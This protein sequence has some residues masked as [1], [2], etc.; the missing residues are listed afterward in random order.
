LSSFDE[1]LDELDPLDRDVRA[2]RLRRR[3]RDD[4]PDSPSP[5]PS[6]LDA[7]SE[8]SESDWS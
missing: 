1:L 7:S 4:V 2:L 3:L 6:S 8:P 5:S